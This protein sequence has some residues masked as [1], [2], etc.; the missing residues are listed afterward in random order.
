MM[1]VNNEAPLLGSLWVTDG[2]C[3]ED[4]DIGWR[5]PLPQ[6]TGMSA[7]IQAV[8]GSQCQVQLIDLNG[9]QRQYTFMLEHVAIEIAFPGRSA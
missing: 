2:C 3:V 9:E 5:V 7:S 6:H 8:D 1:K 4:V